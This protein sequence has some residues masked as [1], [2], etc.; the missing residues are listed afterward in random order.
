MARRPRDTEAPVAETDDDRIVRE[1]KKRFKKCADWEAQARQRWIDDVK[2]V[3]GDSDNLYQWPVNVRNS[4]GQGTEDERPCLTVNKCQQHC[5]QVIN[6]GRQNKSSGKVKPVGD[7]ATYEAAQV[8]EGLVRHTEYISNAQAIYTNV[9]T[10]QVWGGIGYC[11]VVT[12]Y[13]DDV[14]FDQEPFIQP[15]DPLCVYLDPDIKEADG[16]D[17]R[18][19]FVFA[20]IPRDEFEIQ[21]PK[22]QLDTVTSVLGNDEGA[23][24]GEDK[25]R[26]AEYYYRNEVKDK[27]IV[28]TNPETGEK[29][30]IKL[31]ETKGFVGALKEALD[32]AIADPYTKT[33]DIIGHEVKW[34]KIAGNEII[35]RKDWAGDTIPIAFAEG[36]KTVIEGELDRKGHVRAMKDPQR[37]LNYHVSAEAEY[38][39]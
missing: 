14:S 19:G 29:Q 5:F 23:W 27:L 6:D 39:A 4:R 24:V 26:V 2:F 32:E 7:G 33:R 12:N 21:Y 36:I 15:L 10:Y 28:L 31:S 30:P 37:R 9:R 11:R 20:D 25:V 8:F 1:A 22:V 13:V 3:N 35:D 38:V 18:F 34:V 16:S 17:A